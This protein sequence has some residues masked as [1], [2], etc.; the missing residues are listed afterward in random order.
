MNT[1]KTFGFLSLVVLATV[2]CG[3]SSAPAKMAPAPVSQPA[4][5]VAAAPVSAMTSEFGVPECDE[6]F[7]KYLACIDSK[8]PEAARAQVRTGLDQS[9][10][11][12][13]QLAMTPEGKAGLATACKQAL[14]TA[15]TAMSAYGCSF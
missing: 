1:N 12:W 9:K 4:A 6:Y 14:D 15:K 13:K 3:D 8:V 10:A 7:T 5:T 11:S 2:A